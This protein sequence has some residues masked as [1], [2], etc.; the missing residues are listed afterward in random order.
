MKKRRA[1]TIV[2]ILLVLILGFVIIARPHPDTSEELAKCIGSN[3]T[4]YVQKGC[5]A[6]EY[7]E[8]MF[9]D[10]YQYLNVVDCW[11]QQEECLGIKGTPTWIINNEEY[12]GARSIEQ[13]KELTKC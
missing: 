7:Q 2:L 8:K 1:I 3:S 6:C 5:H 4:L 9:G 10:N 12:L 13:L 11:E